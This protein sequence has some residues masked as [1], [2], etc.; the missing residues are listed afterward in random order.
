MNAKLMPLDFVYNGLH[1]TTL[2]RQD[3]TGGGGIAALMNSQPGQATGH[4]YYAFLLKIVNGVEQIDS[5]LSI[6]LELDP[7]LAI[8]GLYPNWPT[9]GKSTQMGD[10]GTGTAG[11]YPG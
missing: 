8:A 6:Q 10:A 7:A 4:L 9:F 2:Y 3:Y 11:A 1:F 5:V